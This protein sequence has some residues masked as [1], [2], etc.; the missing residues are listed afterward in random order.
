MNIAFVAS[1]VVP[2]AKT[3]GLADVS[4]SL[5]I[6]MTKLGHN[7]KVFMPKYYSVDEN[8]FNLEYEA[9]IGEIPI[10]VANKVHNVQIFKGLLDDNTTEIYF[11][12]YPPFFHRHSLYTN[13]DD[14]DERFILFSKAVIELIQRLMWVPEIIH[15]NDWQTALI[16]LLLKDNY[17][18]DKLFTKTATVFTI[19]NI[20]YQGN[21]S[22]ETNDKAEIDIKYFE[23]PGTIEHEGRVNFM[24]AAISFA[25]IITTVSEKY[26]QELLT[27]E[28][29]FGM[30][31]ILNYRKNDLFGILNGID[32]TVWSPKIDVFIPQK[33]SYKS[34]NDKELNKIEL[35]KMVS[36]PYVQNIP[37]I[38]IVSRLAS[39]KGIDLFIDSIN[40]L[41]SLEIK[42]VVL[43]T[44]EFRYEQKLKEIAQNNLDKFNVILGYS[45][46]LAHLITAGSDMFLMPSQFEPCGLTQMYSLKYGTVPIVRNTGGLTD[47][48]FDWDAQIFKGKNNGN[49]FSFN[50]YNGYALTNAVERALLNFKNK[51]IWKQIIQNGMKPS[52]AWKVSAEKYISIYKKALAKK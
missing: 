45:N 15:L 13:D 50:D 23:A 43:G 37:V 47:T 27:E 9:W 41:L 36:L 5:P 12:D 34:I 38:G 35:L 33:Y 4:G 22:K 6:E 24:K 7:I 14:E 18:W 17:S 28:F 44:G 2:F 25:D 10:R 20:A 8:R 46:K 48:V 26:A 11:I 32:E 16:P 39:Q 42:W 3:G 29:S 40:Y 19:H 51:K 1:E 49:G 30:H 52:F 31:T 21:F